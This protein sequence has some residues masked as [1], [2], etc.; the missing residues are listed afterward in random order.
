MVISEEVQREMDHHEDDD[1]MAHDGLDARL[2]RIEVRMNAVEKQIGMKISWPWFIATML[3][4]G[5]MQI[6]M[7]GYLIGQ[8]N[9]IQDDQQETKVGLS[10][11]NGKLAP[12]D[13]SIEK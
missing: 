12:F 11:L 3:T 5:A 6:T 2:N 8:I 9:T 13:F 10:T 4:L 7:F 1:K